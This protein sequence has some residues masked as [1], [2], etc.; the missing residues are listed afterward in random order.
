VTAKWN[1]DDAMSSERSRLDR[2]TGGDRDAEIVTRIPCWQG[3]RLFWAVIGAEKSRNFSPVGRNSRYYEQGI[4]SSRAG[5]LFA[6]AG[7]L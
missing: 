7:N 1:G 6:Q 3:I 2:A 5:R 4:V